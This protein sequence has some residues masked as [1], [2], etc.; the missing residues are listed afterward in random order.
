MLL[1]LVQL[2]GGNQDGAVLLFG[3]FPNQLQKLAHAL[4]VD[5]QGGFVHN[6]HFGVLYQHI[7]HS[8]TLPHASGVGPYL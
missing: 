7:R 3:H 8:K 6:D 5:A 4:R 2:V 1:H